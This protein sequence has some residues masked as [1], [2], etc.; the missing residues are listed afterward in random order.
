MCTE[1]DEGG[2]RARPCDTYRNYSRTWQDEPF[3]VFVLLQRVEIERGM[4]HVEEFDKRT[5]GKFICL[6]RT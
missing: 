4:T 6:S 5:P 3:V 2:V 1:Q